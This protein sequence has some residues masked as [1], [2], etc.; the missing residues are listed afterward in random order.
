MARPKKAETAKPQEKIEAKLFAAA[1][2]LRG[3]MDASEYKHVVLGLIFLKFISD[4]FE[5]HHDK[6]SADLASD[7][8]D[9]EE[10]L[11]ESIFWVPKAARWS[12]IQAAAKT[13]AIGK[14]IDDA[15]AAVEA[16]NDSLKGV[17][18]KDYGRPSL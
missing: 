7:A 11:A 18:P 8:E 12:G 3:A 14:T 1:D 13:D 16:S 17:L 2:K 10:Y 15:M 9:P 6:L 4:A 5:A